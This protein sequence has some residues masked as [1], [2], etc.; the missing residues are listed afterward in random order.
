MKM[1]TGAIGTLAALLFNAGA[2]AQVPLG[3]GFTYQGQL[4]LAGQVLNDTADFEF[5]LWDADT[6]GNVI[7]S[8]VAVS[9]V[10]VVDGLFTVEIDFGLLA[11]N[12]DK[13][14]LEISVRSPSGGGEFT[15]LDPRQPLTAAPYALALPAL[16]T[17]EGANL[18]PNV[19]GGH[20]VNSVDADVS[21]ATIGGGGSDGFPN[22][23]TGD[24]GS[25]GGGIGNTAARGAT[26]GGGVRNTAGGQ[27]SALG[28]GEQNT[29]SGPHSTVPG[30]LGNTASGDIS[31][32]AGLQAKANHDGSFVWADSQGGEFASTAVNQLLIRAA[33]GVGIGTNTPTRALEVAGTVAAD[34]LE[35]AGTVAADALEVAG[36]VTAGGYVGDGSG[37]SGVSRVGS[38]V[39]LDDVALLRW[40][41]L[42]RTF[43]TGNNPQ[44]VAFD[45]ANIW[46]TNANSENV[47]KRRASDGANL[48]T[49]PAGVDP[50]GVAFDGANIWVANQGIFN[51]GNTVTKLR[52]SDGANL[53]T[54]PV[55]VFPSSV[56]FDGANIWVTNTDSSRVTRISLVK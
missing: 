40:D 4:K 29:A 39:D 45:G 50:H 27:N 25:I 30:G 52:A 15:T 11:F 32:A 55:C 2:V 13:R 14:W 19:I 6:L 33:G 21:G 49:F 47:T 22:L 41:R 20:I 5:T 54:F 35:V 51:P 36:T 42:N 12:G 3:G 53:G 34:A 43:G 56:A 16:R 31:F 26:V 38:T 1:R 18:G 24:F 28:G 44:G 48:G 37:L 9:N 17:E 7:G 23:I 10:T 8:V 46:V